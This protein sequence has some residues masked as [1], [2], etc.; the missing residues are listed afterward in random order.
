MKLPPACLE[1]AVDDP[2]GSLLAQL[3]PERHA[4]ETQLGDH[5]PRPAQSPVLHANP[6]KK[7]RRLNPSSAEVLAKRT[8]WM[9]TPQPASINIS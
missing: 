7:T 9:Y 1:E 3:P 2:P 5:Q 4:P 8:P 6:P